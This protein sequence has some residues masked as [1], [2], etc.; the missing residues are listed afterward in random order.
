MLKAYKYRVY[1]NKEQEIKLKVFFNAKRFVWNHFLALNKERL[2]QKEKILTYNEMSALLTK[3]KQQ[4]HWLREAEKSILQNTLKDLHL[5]FID[6]FIKQKGFPHFKSRY[7]TSQSAK[8][9]LTNNN[10]AV[11]AKEI[12]YTTTNKVKKQNCKLKIPKLKDLRIMYS[13]PYEGRIL[14]AT[15]SITPTGKYF[16][17]L[18]CTDVEVK[19]FPANNNMV[20][21]DLGLKDFLVAS[22]GETV[23]NP[24][25]YRKYEAKLQKA[26][27]I[28]SKRK[29]R[30]KN[31]G[32]QRLKVARVHEKVAN[33]RLDLLHKVSAKLV[34]ENQLICYESLKVSNMLKNHKLAKSIADA[35]WGS[36]IF[37]LVYK[38]RWHHRTTIEIDTFFPSSQLCNVCNYQNKETKNLSVREWTCPQ[39][40]THH[41]RDTNA[42]INIL[43]E[44]TR[45]YKQQLIKQ[46]KDTVT[47]YSQAVS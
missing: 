46:M 2:D 5:A 32:K 42:S 26:Q 39:C 38:A 11:K 31:K 21:I 15:I 23:P 8:M 10:I 4:H 29:K 36:F 33:T 45:I 44:G 34:K 6:Y 12:S 27:R 17:S 43:K 40:N 14:S 35:S 7:D 16:V 30:S 41:H 37:L 1:P 3:L 19:T 25:Y 22:N 47:N 13:R 28:L 18:T 24:K 20:G 9:N